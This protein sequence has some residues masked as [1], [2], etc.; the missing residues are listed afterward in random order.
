[1]FRW[2]KESAIC[3]VYLADVSGHN[4]EIDLDQFHR[5]RWFTRGWTLQEL[6]APRSLRFFDNKWYPL[7]EKFELAGAIGSITGIPH[8]IL[9]GFDDLSNASVA[10]RMS[11][12]AKRVTKRKEDLAYCLLGIFD[13]MMPMI[14]GE[15]EH[16]FIRLQEEIIKKTADDSVLAWGMSFGLNDGGENQN[17]DINLFGNALA[18]SPADFMHSGQI[19]AMENKSSTIEGLETAR[20]CLSLRLCLSN[21]KTGHAVGI[22]NCRL[23]NRTDAAV[24]IPLF[25]ITPGAVPREYIRPAGTKALLC[26]PPSE[27]SL[28]PRPIRLRALLPSNKAALSHCKYGFHVA[29]WAKLLETDLDI[30][31]TYSDGQWNEDRAVLSTVMDIRYDAARRSWWKVRQKTGELKDFIFAL[32]LR[33]QQMEVR[34]SCH[35]MVASRDTALDIIARTAADSDGFLGSN[36]ASSD[37]LTLEL[38][39]FQDSPNSKLY[40]TTLGA[41]AKAPQPMHIGV[42]A[43]RELNILA[44]TKL[45]L[46]FLAKSWPVS[47]KLAEFKRPLKGKKQAQDLHL[48]DLLS[49]KEAIQFEISLEFNS[50]QELIAYSKSRQRQWQYSML[51]SL[52]RD[53]Q[54]SDIPSTDNIPN[55]VRRA[56]IRAVTVGHIAAMEYLWDFL[57]ADVT[58]EDS[59]GRG[60]LSLAVATDNIP[61]LES[62]ISM[63]FAAKRSDSR[64]Q[65]PLA[66]A[67]LLGHPAALKMLLKKETHASFRTREGQTVLNVAVTRDGETLLDVAVKANHCAIART[68]LKRGADVRGGFQNQSESPLTARNEPTLAVAAR[69]GFSGIVECLL[70]H[71][72]DANEKG[73]SCFPNGVDFGADCPVLAIA[74]YM[75][76]FDVVNHLLSRKANINAT[77]GSHRTSLLLA[78][79][80]GHDRIVQLLLQQGADTEIPDDQKGTTPLVFS[81]THGH[82][83]VVSLLLE[84]GADIEA[85][86]FERRPPI[87]HAIYA[88]RSEILQLLLTWGANTSA[89][90]DGETPLS[91]AMRLSNTEAVDRLVKHEPSVWTK[92]RFGKLPLQYARYENDPEHIRLLKIEHDEIMRRLE[93]AVSEHDQHLAMET[94]PAFTSRAQK[95]LGHVIGWWE[96]LPMHALRCFAASVKAY[97][98]VIFPRRTWSASKLRRR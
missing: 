16:A 65:S 71:G 60:A 64:G 27:V 34:A 36:I 18:T 86:D 56:F 84:K 77:D 6:L 23:M 72:A 67:A 29:Q 20:G 40:M 55:I 59:E 90:H 9:I 14:Y 28:A 41:L 97:T 95:A 81:I 62:L 21:T 32:E 35:L 33:V 75:G 76:H 88:R 83:K 80:N 82:H 66:T 89:A 52:C 13:V 37:S 53:L 26:V 12:A 17:T 43:D 47:L 2:Y 63:G 25:C 15:E 91:Y 50:V 39:L 92:N 46:E 38:K 22:L 93:A 69:L 94:K 51:T 61:V 70:N 45:L 49:E 98:R 19:V 73:L 3:Y 48:L 57:E 11:W 42:D 85:K 30:V 31:A 68:L 58:V 24:G 44:H 1:M 4:G 7:G 74:A 5:S 96:K 78:A 87:F 10:Q 79:R 54:L 8:G